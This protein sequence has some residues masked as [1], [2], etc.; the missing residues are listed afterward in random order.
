[1][2][3]SDAVA[4]DPAGSIDEL[5]R[6]S[7][8]GSTEAFGELVELYQDR[9]FNYLCGLCGNP[10]DAEDVAQETFV[11]AF[12]AMRRFD[13]SGSFTSWLFV[14]ARRTALNHFRAHRRFSAEPVPEEVDGRD[15]AR[16]LEQAEAQQSVWAIARRLKPDQYEAL[17]L[18]YGEGFSIAEAARIMKT[19]QIRV[20]VLVHRARAQ[21][22]KLLDRGPGRGARSRQTLS[23]AL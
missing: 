23:S 6:R 8:G 3:A 10:H 22:G 16:L 17:W 15:P 5:V 21:L 20:R 11:K 4:N 18:R 9:I 19:N 1:M 2:S 7:R 12:R 14:I 13:S